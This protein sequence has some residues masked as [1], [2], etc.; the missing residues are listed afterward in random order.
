MKIIICP[1]V[2][3][4]LKYK[5][6]VVT[7][8]IMALVCLSAD[9][10]VSQF[11][12]NNYT[13]LF[14]IIIRLVATLYVYDKMADLNRDEAGGAFAAFV[15][16]Y[17]MLFSI[18]FLKKKNLHIKIDKKYS[19]DEQYK[20]LKAYAQSFISKNKFDEAA[21]ILKYIKENLYFSHEDDHIYNDCVR[22]ANN[23]IPDIII[24]NI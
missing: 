21:F 8:I 16:P 18:A 15:F 5:R 14:S 2:K 10:F 4:D 13:I 11:Q 19:N 7:P 12:P 6:D 17:F 9:I 23:E 1:S 20:E 3:Y 24:K 22:K